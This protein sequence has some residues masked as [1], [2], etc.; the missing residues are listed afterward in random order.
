MPSSGVSEDSYNVLIIY[1]K[2]FLK[3]KE[4]EREKKKKRKGKERK[5][6][7]EKKRKEKKRKEKKRRGNHTCKVRTLN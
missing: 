1:N 3:K 2:F 6:R 7:K 5:G 4:K